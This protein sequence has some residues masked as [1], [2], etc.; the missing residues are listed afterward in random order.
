MTLD[1]NAVGMV[2]AAFLSADY[3]GWQKCDGLIETLPEA[4]RWPMRERLVK[5]ALA[6]QVRVDGRESV[7]RELAYLGTRRSAG[8]DYY[9]RLGKDQMEAAIASLV[10]FVRGLP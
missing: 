7:L 8:G 5:H 4:E 3:A 9:A 1:R 2:Q 10:A 6:E